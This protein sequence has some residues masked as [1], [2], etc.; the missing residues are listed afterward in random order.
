MKK[1]IFTLALIAGIGMMSFAQNSDEKKTISLSQEASPKI[2]FTKTSHDFGTIT[3]GT[4]ATIEFKFTNTGNAPLILSSVQASCG[5][6]TPSWP[7][8][9]VGPG[10]T[11]TITAVYNSTN[12]VGSFNKSITVKS[13]TEGGTV[14]LYIRGVVIK[15]EKEPKSPVVVPN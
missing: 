13:N 12:R 1:T 14:I 4:Q 7:K 11:G 2:E 9:P 15:A 3:E 10:E 5:C 6:T 8:E